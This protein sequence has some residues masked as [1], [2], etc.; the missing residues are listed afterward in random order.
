MDN[1]KFKLLLS[2]SSIQDKILPEQKEKIE[3]VRIIGTTLLANGELEIE[4]LALKEKPIE[5]P[6]AQ[7][8]LDGYNIDLDI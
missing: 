7:V 5:L 3:E 1:C 2:P 4:C 8:L 6:N